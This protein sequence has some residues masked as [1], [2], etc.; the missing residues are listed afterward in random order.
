[1]PARHD[2]LIKGEAMVEHLLI[3]VSLWCNTTV[4]DPVWNVNSTNHK[5]R[6]CKV[7]LVKC[8]KE[9]VITPCTLNAANC[10][11]KDKGVLAC[12]EKTEPNP[13]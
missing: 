3:S 9:V 5:I 4:F 8:L 1:V 7:E 13:N 10:I 6:K 12:F 11:Q 2:S